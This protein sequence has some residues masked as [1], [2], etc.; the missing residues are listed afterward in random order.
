MNVFQGWLNKFV[1][2]GEAVYRFI[3]WYL[4]GFFVTFGLNYGQSFDEDFA[5]V[6]KY[7]DNIVYKWNVVGIVGFNIV[8]ITLMIYIL[9]SRI[10]HNRGKESLLGLRDF[11]RKVSCDILMPTY[12]VGASITAVMAYFM[13]GNSTN[14]GEYFISLYSQ[15]RFLL[16]LS[17][18]WF[19]YLVLQKNYV[20][21]VTNDDFFKRTP[22]FISFPILVLIIVSINIMSWV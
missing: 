14:T 9:K 3:L 7:S 17:I 21:T 22:L 2:C 8:F 18:I 16:F 20:C 15:G 13:F 12:C 5:A 11:F 4:L 1:C 19:F 10:D 6:I